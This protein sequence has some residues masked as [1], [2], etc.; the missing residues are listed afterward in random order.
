MKRIKTYIAGNNNFNC[1]KMW[2]INSPSLVYIPSSVITQL[3]LI[4]R[5]RKSFFLAPSFRGV[6]SDELVQ[7]SDCI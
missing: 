3:F 4:I 2:N 5:R 1:K 7:Q 6:Y